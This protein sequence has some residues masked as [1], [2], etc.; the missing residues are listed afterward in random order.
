MH[1]G[2]NLLV[3]GLPRYVPYKIEP[4]VY[5]GVKIQDGGSSIGV[6]ECSFDSTL[7]FLILIS[8]LLLSWCD[9]HLL[10]RL[11]QTYL[12]FMATLGCSR[13]TDPLLTTTAAVTSTETLTGRGTVASDKT[14]NTFTQQENPTVSKVV[15]RLYSGGIRK[16]ATCTVWLTSVWL[17][18]VKFVVE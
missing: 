5:S 6:A 9:Y 16:T 11:T 14:I 18:L 12:S 15:R 13:S 7:L 2:G 8:G 3:P 1:E 17:I 4:R 10:K